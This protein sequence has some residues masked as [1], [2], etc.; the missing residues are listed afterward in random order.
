MTGEADR[1]VHVVRV[2]ARRFL[3]Q[4]TTAV[5]TWEVS[6][7]WRGSWGGARVTFTLTTDLYCVRNQ[8]ANADADAA[9]GLRAATASNG[10]PNLFMGRDG[11]GKLG[12]GEVCR[13]LG[14]AVAGCRGVVM[15][16]CFCQPY[17][18]AS[19]W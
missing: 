15:Q 2:L 6:L 13:Y 14:N 16:A 5:G 11:Q 10:R 9:V 12:V 17:F 4:P 18:R 8:E 19:L 1:V 3:N 7:P